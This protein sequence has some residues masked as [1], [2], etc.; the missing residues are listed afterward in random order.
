MHN[1]PYTFAK[2]ISSSVSLLIP[3]GLFQFIKILGSTRFLL[4][5]FQFVCRAF[6]VQL[7]G[8]IS[9]KCPITTK[10]SS[11]KLIPPLTSAKL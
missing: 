9:G 10:K 4:E 2:M 5:L 3:K 1:Y 8:Q 7:E 11:N 6:N